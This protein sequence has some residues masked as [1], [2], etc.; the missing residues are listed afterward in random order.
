MRA[1]ASN[2]FDTNKS[3]EVP[4][5]LEEFSTGTQTIDLDY[6]FARDVTSSGSFNIRGVQ[7]TSLG[8]LLDA[9]PIPALLL[10]KNQTIFFSNQACDKLCPNREDLWAAPFS[11][12]LPRQG[13]AKVIKELLTAAYR[14]RQPQV[15]EAVLGVQAKIWGKI[16]MRSL[17]IADERFMLILVED[18]TA[19]KKYAQSLRKARDEL[20]LR[21]QERTVELSKA[22]EA[23]LLAARVIASSN[24]A[25]IVTDSKA[26]IV[27]VNEAFCQITGHMKDDILGNNPRV[28]ASG[29][30]DEQFWKT[31]WK[32]L[33][34]KGQWKGEVWNRR[35][36]GAIFPSLLSVSAVRG[37][38]GAATHYVGI[39]SDITKAKESEQR[40]EQLAHY[41]PLTSLP[42]RLLLRDRLNRALIRAARDQKILAVMFLDLD[43]FK[44]VNDTFGHPVGDELLV[45]VAERLNQCAR[46]GDTIARLGG[47]EFIIVMSDLRVSHDVTQ[48]ARRFVNALSNPFS[49]RGN[50][51]F[52]SASIGI[53]I[54]PDDGKDLDELL[55]HADTAMFHAKAQGKNSFQFFSKEMNLAIK[56]LVAMETTFR[57]AMQQ[58]D[59][60]VYHQPVVSCDEG[61][62]LATEALLRLTNIGGETVSAGPFIKVA[63]DKGLIIPVGQWVLETAC[64]QN[65]RWHDLGF[66]SMRVAVNISMHQLRRSDIVNTVV[67]VLEET[68]HDPRNLELELTESA[69]MP[70]PDLTIGI[71]SQLRGHGITI[72]VDDFGTGYSS[73]SY[74][75]Q[76]PVDKIKIDKSFIDDIN[77]D[78]AQRA[79]VEAIVNVAHSLDITV[80][81]EGVESRKQLDVLRSLKCDAFQG[82][83]FSPAIAGTEVQRMLLSKQWQ[84]I[85][86]E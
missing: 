65:K 66:T 30:H 31:F 53:S 43:S 22:N 54:F 23:L 74:L 46:R 51:V 13:E 15:A 77:T 17:R 10:D 26:R 34:Q 7:K 28:I 78:T 58:N 33:Q 8:K 72:S 63:E 50:E 44:T 57:R 4:R 75:R 73:L 27:E 81:A 18:L 16:H 24:E 71:L 37:D 12:I 59:L 35:K 79:L 19:E 47:D 69:M 38:G 52:T 14:E 80:V 61:R 42:N 82:H 32:E 5:L 68:G 60:M 55:Q 11:K 76:L 29:R 84:T 48:A 67:R 39:F 3:P 21:V 86:R 85:R 40:L 83:Y 25:I 62:I 49:L 56:K 64:R 1:P 9:L 41:D 6:F 36:S 45:E 2:G 20:D 70:N